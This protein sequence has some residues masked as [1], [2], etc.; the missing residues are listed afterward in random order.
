MAGQRQKPHY[1]QS[2]G[3]PRYRIFR[4]GEPVARFKDHFQDLACSLDSVPGDARS[5]SRHKA[6]G[7]ETDSVQQLM[8]SL[9]RTIKIGV[10]GCGY[11]GPNLIRNLRQSSDCQLKLVDRK[12]TRLNS[13]HSQIS[14][15]VFCLK[16]KNEGGP[17]P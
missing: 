11:W 6:S 14:Y 7:G 10:V 13:S 9:K 5:Q 4:E 15:A 8:K 3:S 17:L 12:S 16:K 2:D 1:L